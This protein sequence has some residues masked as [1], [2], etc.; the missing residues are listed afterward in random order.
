MSRR[1]PWPIRH[2]GQAFL[3][4]LTAVG[5]ARQWPTTAAAIAVAATAVA[6]AWWWARS[7]LRARTGTTRHTFR[8]GQL[9]MRPCGVY[10]HFFAAPNGHVY[11]GITN[12]YRARTAQHLEGSWWA[13]YAD[14][15][16]SLWQEWTAADCPPGVTPRQM[17]KAEESRLIALYAPIGNTEENPYYRA[18]QPV[19]AQ[20][21]AAIGWTPTAAVSPPRRRY[22][23]IWRAA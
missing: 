4:G 10:Q 23:R 1:R 18:Q 20:M 3:L 16:R 13:A 21:Q 19:R 15:D 2:K 17:A 6:G 7:A 9:D 12:H 14:W 5:A 22:T 11:V 8:G